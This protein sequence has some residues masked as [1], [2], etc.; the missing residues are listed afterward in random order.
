MRI[1]HSADIPV[2]KIWIDRDQR[3]RRDIDVTDLLPSIRKRGV[4][5]AILLTRE[6]APSGATFKLIAG[7]R[8][9]TASQELGLATIPGRFIEDLTP[10][11]LQIIELEENIRRADLKWQEICTSVV[12]IHALFVEAD[13]NWTQAMTGEEVGYSHQRVGRL[14]I[15]WEH[16]ENPAVWEATGLNEAHNY[17][18]RKQERAGNEALMELI[19]PGKDTDPGVIYDRVMGSAISP[20][21]TPVATP[22]SNP[23]S[24]SPP[25]P[26]APLPL[27]MLRGIHV[28]D[29]I[30]FARSYSGEKFNFIHCD[31]PYGINV[32]S[33]PQGRE[34]GD[35]Q[36]SGGGEVGYDDSP[37]VYFALLDALLNALPRLASY[38]THFMFW[39]SAKHEAE[40]RRRFAA[41]APGVIWNQHPLIW[42]KTDN[43]GISP[44]ARRLPRHIYETAL[45]GSQGDRKIVRIAADAYSAPT[46]KSLHPSTKPEPV[47]RHFF[48]MLVDDT[49][50]VFD[51]TCG[52]G[53]SIRAA[54]SFGAKRTLGLELNPE[55]AATAQRALKDSLVK[56]FAAKHVKQQGKNTN[57]T[58]GKTGTQPGAGTS[59]DGEAG[60]GFA[61]T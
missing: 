11:E 45:L 26:A 13:P 17:I 56:A 14:L 52:S 58:E 41:K 33:G 10:M 28:A 40:T 51:P 19:G 38:S 61:I 31:F 39:Y 3:Q 16:R 46:D 60:G 48:Q 43:L 44:D 25:V 27:P 20:V 1:A 34:G 42:V 50:L 35:N 2:E 15:A 23:P 30:E 12:K 49:S 9:L 18:L 21:A 24:A 53:S 4:M 55:I 32:F 7:E 57:G 36:R 59:G 6:A 22:G 5:S 8:R 29:F 47:L 54:E 37:D